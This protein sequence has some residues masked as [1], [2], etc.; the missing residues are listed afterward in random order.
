[1][2][3]KYR[4]SSQY[5]PL[6]SSI[7]A[8]DVGPSVRSPP[9][10]PHLQLGIGMCAHR[11][12]IPS[13]DRWGSQSGRTRSKTVHNWAVRTPDITTTLTGYDCY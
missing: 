3:P 8:N 4:L 13:W 9:S 7:V 11:K 10:D 1:M 12:W 6:Q 2:C 5:L